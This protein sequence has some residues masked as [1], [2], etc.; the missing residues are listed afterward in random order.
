MISAKARYTESLPVWRN[1]RPGDLLR[2]IDGRGRSRLF[3]IVTIGTVGAWQEMQIQEVTFRNAEAE[4]PNTREGEEST[5]E[6]VTTEEW[7]VERVIGSLIHRLFPMNYYLSIMATYIHHLFFVDGA[8]DDGTIPQAVWS[9]LQSG[10][11]GRE[12]SFVERHPA[13]SLKRFWPRT[14]EHPTSE[15]RSLA[16]GIY[17]ELTSAAEAREGLQ[18]PDERGL[19]VQLSNLNDVLDAAVSRLCGF[20]DTSEL[21][22][23]RSSDI[24]E[25]PDATADDD[26]K[27]FSDYVQAHLDGR[28]RMFF[29]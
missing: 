9:M 28:R 6:A 25:M 21:R 1:N 7:N 19:Y 16:A 24:E 26:T 8:N 27:T 12:H 4:G 5:A 13:V 3:C 23:F 20:R 18:N 11:T 17:L 29:K 15:V 10:V 14:D 2:T 22:A